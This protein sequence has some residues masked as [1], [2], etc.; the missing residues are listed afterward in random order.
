M[1]SSKT[2]G[3]VLALVLGAASAGLAQ[4]PSQGQRDGKARQEWQGRKQHDGGF[5]MLLKGIE[6]TA[7]QKTQLQALRGKQGSEAQRTERS[8]VREQMRAAR[9]SGDTAALRA[10]RTQQVARMQ[11]HREAMFGQ[12][13]TILTPAQ[14]EVFD[15]NVAEAKT[16][17]EKH[18]DGVKQRR[19]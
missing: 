11:Q 3:L 10:L 8:A 17:F 15:R 14:Q 6:L 12:I 2:A 18:G 19:S 5:G 7:E 16:R 9:E 1:R 13:R 4:Q